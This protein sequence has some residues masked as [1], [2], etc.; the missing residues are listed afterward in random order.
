MIR[1][2]VGIIDARAGEITW[3][4]EQEVAE[5]V[6]F[7]VESGDMKATFW[8]DRGQMTTVEE[9]LESMRP[10]RERVLSPR[11]AVELLTR[12]KMVSY[13]YGL[14]RKEG[15]REVQDVTRTVLEGKVVIRVG[16]RIRPI[17]SIEKK[18]LKS[19]MRKR[20]RESVGESGK[21]VD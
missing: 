21:T 4:G 8:P 12:G 15:D 1:S 7:L 16:D 18:R 17:R 9:L 20:I 5:K 3:T 14:P 19:A 11:G 13:R 10:L 2:K 6:E